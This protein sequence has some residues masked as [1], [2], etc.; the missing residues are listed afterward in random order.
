MASRPLAPL[1]RED[2]PMTLI[3]SGGIGMT[4]G[5]GQMKEKNESRAVEE[6]DDDDDDVEFGKDE[7]EEEEEES[8]SE[9]EQSEV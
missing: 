1:T 3:P 7:G 9:E 8:S 4:G 2:T 6:Y 5:S